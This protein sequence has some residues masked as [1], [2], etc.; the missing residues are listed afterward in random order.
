M[1]IIEYQ[2]PK[3]IKDFI[4]SKASKLE[5][6]TIFEDFVY[7][8]YQTK[9]EWVIATS[10]YDL[11]IDFICYNESEPDSRVGVQAKNIKGT[12]TLANVSNIINHSKTV[13]Y[14]KNLILITTGTLNAQAQLFCKNNKIQVLDHDDV[15]KI[16]EEMNPDNNISDSVKDYK[17]MLKNIRRQLAKEFEVEKL[18]YIFSNAT[19]EDLIRLKPQSLEDLYKIKGLGTVKIQKYGDK[20][21]SVF[22]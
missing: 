6:G 19:L 3:D 7:N 21:L 1:G 12:V 13:Y 17:T 4:N 8:Y 2:Y 15:C 18:Y 10:K 16:I 9:F 5:K 11:G 20:I 22:L 14:C